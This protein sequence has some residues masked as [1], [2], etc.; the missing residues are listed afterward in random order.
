VAE[1][2]NRTPPIPPHGTR[3]RGAIGQQR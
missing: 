1:T 2:P 3:I